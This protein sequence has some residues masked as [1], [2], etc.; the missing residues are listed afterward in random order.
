MRRIG[1]ICMFDGSDVTAGIRL[2]LGRQ[3][4]GAAGVRAA[5]IESVAVDL[6]LVSFLA[7]DIG[8]PADLS[9]FTVT[10]LARGGTVALCLVIFKRSEH[11][12]DIV[13]IE[14]AVC[15]LSISK[16]TSYLEI[17]FA[18]FYRSV[19]RGRVVLRIH[20]IAIVALAGD[21]DGQSQ[22]INLEGTVV[23]CDLVDRIGR[24]LQCTIPINLVGSG[25]CIDLI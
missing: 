4:D 2:D 20:G 13:L 19:R 24:C 12:F 11:L 22:W 16:V 8:V 18:R 6:R 25:S 14:N 15:R 23:D 17:V 10:V 9:V 5:H 21:S 7:L 3:C 1:L